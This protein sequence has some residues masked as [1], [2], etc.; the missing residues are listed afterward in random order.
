VLEETR[1]HDTIQNAYYSVQ[2]MQAHGWNS[3]EIVSSGSHL[4]RASLIF[5]HFPIRYRT[6]GSKPGAF[7][8]ECAAYLHEMRVTDRLRLL[9]FKHSRY[10]PVGK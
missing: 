3:A 7:W 9:G 8:Y 4:A 6:H 10:L 5:A 1:A 2:I